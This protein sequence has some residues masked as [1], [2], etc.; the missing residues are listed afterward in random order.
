MFLRLLFLLTFVPFL[1]IY[2]LIRLGTSVGWPNTFAIV[3]ITGFLGAWFLK[4][5]GHS[6]LMQVQQSTMQNQLPSDALA[7]GFFT[8]VG[9]LL[10]LTPGILTDAIGLSLIFPLTQVFWKK[11][12]MNQW[13]KA[14]TSGQVQFYSNFPSGSRQ[15]TDSDFGQSQN[16]FRPQQPTSFKDNV[17]DIQARKSETQ[18]KK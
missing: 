3:F 9:G 7:K 15:N 11:Y 16:P 2:F 12:F 10:L 14:M 13:K 1:E 5:Q 17:I 4:K 18:D 8:F 6:I